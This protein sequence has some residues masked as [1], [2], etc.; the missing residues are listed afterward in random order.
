MINEITSKLNEITQWEK[1]LQ[2]DSS[3]NILIKAAHDN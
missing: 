1:D 2:D 3:N